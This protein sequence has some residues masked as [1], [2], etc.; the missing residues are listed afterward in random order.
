MFAVEKESGLKGC[1]FRTA[2]LDIHVNPDDDCAIF[3]DELCTARASS[4]NLFPQK[5]STT[6]LRATLE[7]WAHVL[8]LRQ[9]RIH[10]FQLVICGRAARFVR[11]DRAGATVSERFDFIEQPNILAEFI[12]R[13]AHLSREQRGWDPTATLATASQTR[14]FRESVQRYLDSEES[15]GRHVEGASR[16]LQAETNRYPTWC[17]TIKHGFAGESAYRRPVSS[18]IVAQ[19]FA[20]DGLVTVCGRATR[21]Y[22][23]YDTRLKKVVFFK[24]SW[25]PGDDSRV[26]A[27]AETYRSLLQA[28]VRHLPPVI[29]AGDVVVS[30]RAPRQLTKTDNPAQED[31]VHHRVVQDIIYPLTQARDEQEFVRAVRDAVIG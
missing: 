23:G 6:V 2:S 12:W 22:L 14:L 26:R 25:R 20:G 7:E 9:Q 11:W 3:D 17:L 19:P 15:A 21:A 10:L 27:E 31:R 30:D 1:I 24:D 4:T 5:T 8:F 16:T 28:G 13:F 18:I 29:C